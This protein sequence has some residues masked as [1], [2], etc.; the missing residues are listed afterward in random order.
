MPKEALLKLRSKSIESAMGS[1]TCL[2]DRE[3]NK[4]IR[5]LS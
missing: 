3:K 5:R 2:A 4:F 1:K